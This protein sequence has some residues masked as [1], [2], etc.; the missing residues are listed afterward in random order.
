MKPRKAPA[1]HERWM[2][3]A[4]NEASLA[5]KH[6]DVPIGA[7]VVANEA[8]I[9]RGHNRRAIDNDPL[10]HAEVLA[11][12]QA[13]QTRGSWRLD[14][15]TLYVTLEPCPM[16]AGAL[17]QARVAEVVYALADPRG[18][19]VRSLYQICDDRRQAH[20]LRVVQG[21][22]EDASQQLLHSFFRQKRS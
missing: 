15:V 12:R 21:P 20:R 17:V 1:D 7:V 6:D 19:A 13:A 2:Q 10:A 8:I 14:D 16:C 5:L 11:L 4:L 18:G 9:G 22:C 3:H